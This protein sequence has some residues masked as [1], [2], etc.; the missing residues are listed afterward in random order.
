MNTLDKNIQ[1]Y[2]ENHSQDDS[3]ILKQL[4]N[5]DYPAKPRWPLDESA[6]FLKGAGIK[7]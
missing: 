5:L 3:S 4:N 1:Y 6:P 7:L 2:C